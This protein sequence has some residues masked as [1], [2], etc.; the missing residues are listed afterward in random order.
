MRYLLY[1]QQQYR[2]DPVS[3]RVPRVVVQHRVVVWRRRCPHPLSPC[4]S[5]LNEHPAA[6][7]PVMQQV[8]VQMMVMH[9]IRMKKA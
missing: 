4:L 9:V 1:H 2:Y 7:D 3:E 8:Q 6:L 5:P